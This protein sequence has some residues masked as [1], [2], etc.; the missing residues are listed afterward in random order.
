MIKHISG[1]FMAIASLLLAIGV[2]TFASACPVMP[3][4]KFMMCHWAQEVVFGLGIVL[5]LLSIVHLVSKK[6]LMKRGLSIAI[7]LNS[8]LTVLV[9]GNFVHLCMKATMRCHT[10]MKPFVMVVGGVIAL[11]ALID[12]FMQR[13][14]ED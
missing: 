2:K 14:I 1:I 6:A 3:N 9:P 5:L 10:V 8:V 13:K 7:F 4:G 11:V 12:F